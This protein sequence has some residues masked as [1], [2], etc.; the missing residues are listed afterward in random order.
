[1]LNKDIREAAREAGVH[2]WRI[3]ERLKIND[4]NFSRRLR[5]ELSA[6]EKTQIERIIC[7]L[8]R[9]QEVSTNE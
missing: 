1:M 6:E 4:G 8:K 5:R 2:L 3:A 9:E 7:D